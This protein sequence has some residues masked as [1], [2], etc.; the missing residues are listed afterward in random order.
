MKLELLQDLLDVRGEAVEVGLEVGPQLLLPAAGGQVAESERGRV[1]E[2]FTGCLTE[3]SVL[4][5]H[6]RAVQLSLHTENRVLRR[7][8]D[9]IQAADD[10]HGQNDVAVLA[11]DID[12]AQHIVRD[13]PYEAAN[14][15]GAH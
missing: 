8:Q 5:C 12:I 9:G 15:Q 1:V 11:P 7:L 14:V 10:G 4:V 3:S 13:A 6:A 2:G